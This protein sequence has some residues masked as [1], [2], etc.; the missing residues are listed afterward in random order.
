ML[1]QAQF[2]GNPLGAVVPLNEH[3]YTDDGPDDG[4]TG[5]TQ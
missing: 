2:C 5:Q 3:M 4:G 1:F